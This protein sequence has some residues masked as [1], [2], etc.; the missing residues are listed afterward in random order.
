MKIAYVNT[1][2]EPRKMSG[3]FNKFLG[4]K[5]AAEKMGLPF[6]FHLFTADRTIREPGLSTHLLPASTGAL[7]RHITAC[8]RIVESM[9][10]YDAV[11]MREMMAS[12]FYATAF[13]YKRFAL[14]TEHNS[15]ILAELKN[16]QRLGK[17][18]LEKL[19]GRKC[20]MFSDGIVAVT[21]EIG[22]SVRRRGR[23]GHDR[24]T[25]IS[26]GIDV[27]AL[28]RSS[29]IT[30][31]GRHLHIG[32]VAGGLAVWH[33]LDRL[34]AGLNAYTGPVKITLHLAGPIEKEALG[35][36]ENRNV[37]VLRYGYLNGTALDDFFNNIHVA[38]GSLAL[39]RLGLR[40]ACVLKSREYAARGVPFIYAYDDADIPLNS[41]FCLNI[42]AA[43]DPIDMASL[44][45]WAAELPDGIHQTLR[46]H[47][48]TVMDWT[49]KL[50][51]LTR[52]IEKITAMG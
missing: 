15:D 2:Y 48:K 24:I 39:H 30:F 8:D 1:T 3:V 11:V 47:A 49:V 19:F 17:Y 20:L 35:P 40:Q 25:T 16:D 31:D 52:F 21:D 32:F 10:G 46:D 50:G 42:R 37:T 13:R 45:A 23:H 44:I 51:M 29:G 34:T 5:R 14:I 18:W 26:N 9:Q 27:E 33:G 4:Q 41:K 12:P 38:V 43:E 22:E 28:P 36:I 6:D 7:R